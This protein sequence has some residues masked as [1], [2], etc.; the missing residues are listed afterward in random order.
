MNLRMIKSDEEIK[1]INN[2][3]RIADLGGEEIVRNI[4]REKQN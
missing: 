2:G 1:I 3:A 4:K